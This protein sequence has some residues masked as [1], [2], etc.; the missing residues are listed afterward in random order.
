MTAEN[1]ETTTTEDPR[2][3]ARQFEILHTEVTP[4]KIKFMGMSTDEMEHTGTLT[5]KKKSYDEDTKEFVD[6]PEV[7]AAAAETLNRMG[8]GAAVSNGEIMD[9][10]VEETASEVG[11]FEGYA[12]VENNRLSLDPIKVFEKPVSISAATNKHFKSR[13]RLSDV[14]VTE[15][16]VLWEEGMM[17]QMYFRDRDE[18]GADHLYK[19]SQVVAEDE[20]GNEKKLSVKFSKGLDEIAKRLREGKYD[21]DKAK[22][23]ERFV[24]VAAAKQYEDLCK[25]YR[26]LLGW[27]LPKMIEEGARFKFTRTMNSNE[28]RGE[29]YYSVVAT[30]VDDDEDAVNADLTNLDGSAAE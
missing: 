23:M 26:D 12:D 24:K 29:T 17:V 25:K 19:I 3:V 13:A 16:L 21:A 27:D 1:T 7:Y 11:F 2:K 14:L 9:E 18:T 28:F 10:A 30:P 5:I 4:E 8:L 6:D 22:K 15:P 20:S